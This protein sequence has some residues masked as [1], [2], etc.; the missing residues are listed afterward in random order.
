MKFTLGCSDSRLSTKS[1][2]GE[3]NRDWGVNGLEDMETSKKR[4]HPR[5]IRLMAI[6][7]GLMPLFLLEL[8][9]VILRLPDST[10]ALTEFEEL[11]H[12]RPL[13]ELTDDGSE[14]RIA[15]DRL[16]WFQPVSFTAQ[17][18]DNEYR[19]FALG[20]STTQ[21]EPYSTETAFPE[22]LKLNLQAADEQQQ[23]KVINCGGLSY[24]SY[25]VLAILREVLNYQ[26]DAIVIYTGQNEYLEKRTYA[27]VEDPNWF[28]RAIDLGARLRSVQ[29]IQRLMNNPRATSSKD[30]M[31]TIAEMS[32]Q[33]DALLDYSGGLE[34]YHRDDD[35]RAPVVEHFRWN[36]SQMMRLCKENGTPVVFVRPVTNLLDC[37]PFK[38]EP[39]PKLGPEQLAELEIN[40]QTARKSTDSAESLQAIDQVLKLDPGHCG[41]LFL[42]GKL[43]CAVGQWKAGHQLLKL[44]R[45]QDVCPLRAPT[46]IVEAVTEIGAFNDV[47]VVDAEKLFEELSEHGVVGANWLV[48]HVHPT[49]EG[50]QKIGEAIADVFLE[51]RWVSITRP[52][53]KDHIPE[54]YRLHLKT[55]GE[56][57]FHRGKQRLEGLRLWTEGRAKKVREPS[58]AH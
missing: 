37:P 33:V 46:A 48:D 21:G 8:V 13:F 22:W 47:P 43:L 44:A 16:R 36:L 9:L 45:D 35:W 58:G 5:A 14:Y 30:R 7:L 57:Y 18:S 19:I 39:D 15:S 41:A 40:W 56:A 54:T 53:W 34:E 50:H 49:V 1:N 12:V 25:R 17:K 10:P 31:S 24:A 28:R 52:D 11:H 51:N 2:R 6:G 3:P 27:E 42:K 4:S 20:G 29:C 55:L 38:I 23:F 26:P 32:E